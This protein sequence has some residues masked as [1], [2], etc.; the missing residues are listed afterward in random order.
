MAARNSRNVLLYIKRKRMCTIYTDK[1]LYHESTKSSSA[2]YVMFITHF[3]FSYSEII[4]WKKNSNK[5][6]LKIIQWAKYI[7]SICIECT[8]IH[9]FAFTEQSFSYYHTFFCT[10]IRYMYIERWRN[11]SRRFNVDVHGDYDSMC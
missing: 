6:F 9:F 5:I 4:F 8:I 11:T 10:K 7:Y 3:I 2:T 1:K